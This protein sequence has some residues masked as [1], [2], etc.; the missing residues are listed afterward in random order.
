M[1]QKLL[2]VKV[3]QMF[4]QCMA[5][6]IDYEIRNPSLVFPACTESHDIVCH[7]M[8]KGPRH[9]DIGYASFCSLNG[10]SEDKVMEREKEHYEQ[11][12]NEVLFC[13]LKLCDIMSNFRRAFNIVK[14]IFIFLVTTLF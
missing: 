12:Q 1:D 7:F 2:I 9:C 14:L 4:D 11:K 5:F 10:E 13:L 6:P 8:T 3:T